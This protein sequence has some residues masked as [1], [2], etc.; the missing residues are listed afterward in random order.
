M[1]DPATRARLERWKLSLLDLSTGNRL[2]D[3]REGRTSIA[4]PG[5]DPVR[6]AASIASGSTFAFES[7]LD[8]ASG[9]QAP[10]CFDT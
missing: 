9:S 6:L 5:V 3:A 1:I 2:I 8:S 10:A 7:T 4:L